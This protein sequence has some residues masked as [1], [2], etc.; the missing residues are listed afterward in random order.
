MEGPSK[1]LCQRPLGSETDWQLLARLLLWQAGLSLWPWF[2]SNA[3]FQNPFP[4]Q[5]RFILDFQQSFGMLQRKGWE[6]ESPSG[7]HLSR[8]SEQTTSQ[9]NWVESSILW[10]DS[11][12]AKSCVS[13]SHPLTK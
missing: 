13:Y 6:C 3:T 9:S 12:L 4:P 1:D 7:C 5:G 10:L 11:M 8:N 2:L